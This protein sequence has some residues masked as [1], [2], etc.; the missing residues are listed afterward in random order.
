M[1][2]VYL[3]D[4]AD[5]PVFRHVDEPGAK[6]LQALVERIADRIGRVLEKRGLVERDYENAWLAAD[7]AGT[8]CRV[9]LRFSSAVNLQCTD[10]GCT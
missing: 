3:A 9:V 4:G 1:Y 10:A 8:V 2:G 5:S 7:V 6:A